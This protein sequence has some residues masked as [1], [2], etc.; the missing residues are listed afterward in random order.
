[1]NVDQFVVTPGYVL[2]DKAEP[3]SRSPSPEDLCA[4]YIRR[5]CTLLLVQ[6]PVCS[7][8]YYRQEYECLLEKL[9]GLPVDFMVVPS[10]DSQVLHAGMVRYFAR[11]KCPFIIV[12]T[13]DMDALEDVAWGWISQAQCYKRIPL[14]FNVKNRRNTETNC[15]RLWVNLCD[16]Y[17]IIRLTDTIEDGALT[18]KNLKD[19]GIYPY[20]GALSSQ[21]YADYNLYRRN[22]EELVDEDGYFLYHEAVPSVTVMRGELLQT[23]QIIETN[24]SGRHM[25]SSIYQHFV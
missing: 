10:V 2:L 18:L 11:E 23:D 16:N 19:S 17:G 8:N 24:T 4:D 6:P 14:T 1:M 15:E 13:E 12:E 9:K 20:K 7:N 25:T 22:Q 5:G 3:V 21:A